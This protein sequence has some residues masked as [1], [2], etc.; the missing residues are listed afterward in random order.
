[1]TDSPRRSSFASTTTTKMP[2]QTAPPAPIVRVLWVDS[3]MPIN[4]VGWLV[5]K[6]ANNILIADEYT[7]GRF[8][9]ELEIRL[10]S[11]LS[12]KDVRTGEEL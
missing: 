8:L 3:R 12:I 6:A 11:V 7:N 2:A 5:R 10:E 1:M 4:S 9:G